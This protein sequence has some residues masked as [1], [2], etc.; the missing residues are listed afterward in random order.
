[1]ASRHMK[2]CSTSQIIREMQIKTTVRYYLTSVRMAINEKFTNNMDFPHGP[3][4]KT[5]PSKA[6]NTGL[7]PGQG[8]KIPHA[9]Q[10]KKTK[11]KTETIL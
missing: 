1:M 10:K 11:H 9:G 4:V 2:R 3:V 8:S 6:G 5:S 7:I